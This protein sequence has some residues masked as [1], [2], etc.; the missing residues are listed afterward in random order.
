MVRRFFKDSAIYAVSTLLTRAMM[1]LLVPLYTRIL[2]PAALGRVY[3]LQGLLSIINI[4]ISIEIHQGMGMRLSASTDPTVRR[5]LAA[6]ALWFTVAIYAVFLAATL[7]FSAPLA[8]WVFGNEGETGAMSAMLW[9][10]AAMGVYLIVSAQL[11]WALQP[12]LSAVVSI[13]FTIANIAGAVVL[14]CF[15]HWGP[16]GVLWGVFCGCVAATVLTVVLNGKSFVGR[17]SGKEFRRML[18]LSLPL[19]PSSVAV[20]GGQYANQ[21][22][23][24][25]LGTEADVG[26]FGVM[27]RLASLVGLAMIGF[28]NALTPLVFTH[29]AEPD[30]PS[31]LQRIF[32]YFS[33]FAL[34]LVAGICLFAE[35]IILVLSTKDYLQGAAMLTVL[36]PA[37]LLQQIY[38]FAPGA[39]IRH[40]MWIVSGIN[41]A[42]VILAILLNYL[43]IPTM[44]PMGAAWATLAASAIAFVIHM[45]VSQRYYPV[46]HVWAPLV[47]GCVGIAVIVWTG[48]WLA[49]GETGFFSGWLW[50]LPLFATAAL[51]LVGVRLVPRENLLRRLPSRSGSAS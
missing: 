44:G 25:D 3:L 15:L 19:L 23:L 1:L 11:R 26:T 38:P 22:I 48:R 12:R 17:W 5:S 14:V 50:R 40:K 13:F 35:Q 43:L 29:Y 37:V 33:V 7:P 21:L 28:S 18:M 32:R 47:L 42:S 16:A 8:R 9:A 27:L 49:A 4:V 36:V 39:W 6:T 20:F 34:L 24:H 10:S 51:W 41:I 31:S 46:P 30:T 45:V 2:D